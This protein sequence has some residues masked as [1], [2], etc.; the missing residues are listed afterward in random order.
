MEVKTMADMNNVGAVA[1]ALMKF[2]D[3]MNNYGLCYHNLEQISDICPDIKEHVEVINSWRKNEIMIQTVPYVVKESEVEVKPPTSTQTQTHTST[4]NTTKSS[5]KVTR[6]RL[7]GAKVVEIAQLIADKYD[8]KKLDAVV[9]ALAKNKKYKYD[10]RTFRNLVGK[11]T[12]VDLTN[13]YFTIVDD[14]I[15][16]T[17]QR[18]ES[19]FGNDADSAHTI[20]ELLDKNNGD[21]METITEEMSADD[22]IRIALVRWMGFRKGKYTNI[23]SPTKEIL[24][25]SIIR[26]NKSINA[27]GVVE[28]MNTKYNIQCD[29]SEVSVIKNG[30]SYK[31][32]AK[33]LGVIE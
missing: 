25:M 30:R 27:T 5:Q 9:T 20:A 1:K 3:A 22:I 21:I 7:G 12:Y 32:L 19:V 6:N 18:N 33:T 15:H 2:V 29:V 28:I 11:V 4:T 24:M 16:K 10:E 17:I 23:G 31:S 14:K 26:E 13:P 8:G